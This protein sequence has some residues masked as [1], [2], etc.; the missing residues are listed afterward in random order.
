MNYILKEMCMIYKCAEK[1]E[2]YCGGVFTIKKVSAGLQIVLADWTS[3]WNAPGANPTITK[4][5]LLGS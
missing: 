5:P 2:L 1:L 3:D 4:L